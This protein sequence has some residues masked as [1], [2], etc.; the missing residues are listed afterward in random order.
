MEKIVIQIWKNHEID[1]NDFKN[2]LVN[3]IPSKLRPDLASYQVNL[4]DKMLQKL[5]G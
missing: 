1:D 5:Q 4:P 2:F 3:E